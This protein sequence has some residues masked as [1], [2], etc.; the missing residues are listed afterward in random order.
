MKGLCFA[1][2]FLKADRSFV[3]T[4]LQFYAIFYKSPSVKVIIFPPFM[5]QLNDFSQQTAV[6]VLLFNTF[7]GFLFAILKLIWLHPGLK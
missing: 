7:L 1:M 6:S 5:A 2:C 4:N 3:G